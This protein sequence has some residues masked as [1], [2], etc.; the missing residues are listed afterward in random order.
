MKRTPAKTGTA[1]D[2]LDARGARCCADRRRRVGRHCDRGVARDHRRRCATTA[3]PPC[4]RCT[5][6]FDG[7]ELGDLAVDADGI[8]A[9]ERRLDAR[10]LRDAIDEARRAHR[11]I[12]PRPAWPRR[13]RV[14]TAPGVRCERMLRAD[15]AASAVRAGRLA[16][17]CRR[18]R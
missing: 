3:T 14:D 7:V 8:R 18:R 11:G 17:R 9:A 1:L 10:V 12:P 2:A 16:R 6:R 15:P 13:I 5:R 4:A